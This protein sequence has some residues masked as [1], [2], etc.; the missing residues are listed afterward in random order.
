MT[1]EPQ[2]PWSLVLAQAEELSDCLYS[3]GQRIDW[4]YFIDRMERHTNWDFG[5]TMDSPD[6]RRLQRHIRAYRKNG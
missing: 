6:I 3:D 5:S 1:T 2:D 4:E